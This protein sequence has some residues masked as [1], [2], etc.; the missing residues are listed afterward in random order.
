[1]LPQTR[2][3]YSLVRI[4]WRLLVKQLPFLFHHGERLPVQDKPLQV[5]EIFTA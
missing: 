1:M 5:L 3:S 2:V 4:P